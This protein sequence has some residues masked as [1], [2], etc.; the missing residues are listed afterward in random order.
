M[1]KDFLPLSLP[2][3]EEEEKKEVLDTLNSNWLTT[4]PKTQEFEELIKNYVGSEDT[5][6]LNSCTAALHLALIASEIGEGD[7]VITTPFTFAATANVIVHQRAKP[8]FADVKETLNIDPQEIGKKIT[9]KT[10]A[11]IPVHFAGQP[12]EM[13]EIREIAER[14]NLVVIEDAAHALGAEYRGKKIG[15]LSDFTCFSFHPVKNITTGEGGMLASLHPD[16][17]EKLRSLSLHGMSKGARER[18]TKKGI[19]HYQILYPGYKYN[20]S[21]LQASLGLVQFRKL[22]RFNEIREKYTQMYREALKDLEEI[23]IPSQIENIVHA[24]HLFIIILNLE[25]LKITRDEFILAIKK[26]NIGAGVYY[27][28]LHLHPFYQKAFG[29]QPGDFPRAKYFSERVVALPL[30]PKMEEG[31]LEDVIIALKKIIKNYQ[32]G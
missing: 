1:R 14:N 15:S 9:K 5:L 10:K 26:E 11:I 2:T 16:L 19:S 23:S 29:Y 21:D 13:D 32:K 27:I 31:D 4:G 7:E 28:S 18:F 22:E 12:C 30:F 6:A 24:W 20:M 8:V 17:K 3:I 25:K